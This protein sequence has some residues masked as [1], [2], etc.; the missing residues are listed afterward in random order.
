VQLRS[1]CCGVL[2]V[3]ATTLAL[4][5]CADVDWSSP[6][7]WFAKPIDVAGRNAGYTFSEL[8]ETKQQ[9][10][11][12]TAND[13]V[14][15]NGSCPPPAVAPAPP[16]APGQTAVPA[17]PPDT[18]AL[19]GGGVALGM[20]ECDVVF[21]AGQPSAVQIGSLPNGDRTAV[22]T[23]DSG[24]RAGIYHFQRGTLKVMDSVPVAAAPP[25]AVKKKSAKAAKPSKAKKQN[26]S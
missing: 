8:Q 18:T 19:L 23:F 26:E 13:L 21:R 5:G 4:G 16:P 24:P 9:Q 22:L 2:T 15:S 11:P 25:Q 20:S 17:A 6:Q 1:N 12:I 7:A 3:L 10:H 14:N